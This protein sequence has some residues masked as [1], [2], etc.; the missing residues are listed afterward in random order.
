[1]ELTRLQSGRNSTERLRHHSEPSAPELK[2]RAF[3]D[4]VGIQYS[5]QHPT[6]SGFVLDFAF[7]EQQKAIEV[8]GYYH[9]FT[10]SKDVFRDHI[11][12][13]GG[14]KI[15]RIP[16]EELDDAQTKRRIIQFLKPNHTAPN[17]TPALANRTLPYITQQGQTATNQT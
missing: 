8:D 10:K 16:A 5:Y 2:L 13:R 3:L 6:R 12:K 1:L 17:H 15:L 14:W 9:Q 7:L 4:S 11:L